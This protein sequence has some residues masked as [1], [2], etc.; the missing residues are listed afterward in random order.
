MSKSL[1]ATKDDPAVLLR[2][3]KPVLKKVNEAAAKSGRS[4]NTEILIRLEES[5]RPQVQQSEP[6]TP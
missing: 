5:F 6:V 3:P 4:R 2:V 1:I